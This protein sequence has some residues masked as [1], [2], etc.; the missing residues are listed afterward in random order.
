MHY[1]AIKRNVLAGFTTL[2]SAVY[3]TLAIPLMLKTIGIPTSEAFFTTCLVIGLTTCA[4]GLY[5]QQPIAA[6]PGLALTS[7]VCTEI[8]GRL[9]FTLPQTFAITITTGLIMIGLTR[10][11]LVKHIKHA[12]SETLI[13]ATGV[14][15]GLFFLIISI[16]LADIPNG[17]TLVHL[18][19]LIGWGGTLAV[20]LLLHH[21]QC[22]AAILAGLLL[23]TG[24]QHIGFPASTTPTNIGT[25]TLIPSWQPS[26]HGLLNMKA[27][28]AIS[29][30]ILVSVIDTIATLHALLDQ[31]QSQQASNKAAPKV[32]N[33]LGM[34]FMFSGA[35]GNGPIGIY[36]ESGTG[37]LSGGRN[38]LTS[39]T[40]GLGFLC[41]AGLHA[42]LYLIPQWA[43]AA[44]LS[45]VAIHMIKNGH[46][47]PWRYPKKMLAAATIFITVP[48]T[49]SIAIGVG[50][51]CIAEFLQNKWQRQ[52]NTPTLAW[53]SGLFAVFFIAMTWLHQSI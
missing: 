16:Q 22:P 28:F 8:V 18:H 44:A 38:W 27:F 52:P 36:L 10:L 17:H 30:L 42:W 39:V 13:T 6:G 25:F 9:H 2:L 29:T 46:K 45:F 53:L 41:C 33:T 32:L 15:I 34:A 23:A 12:L 26:W 31:H 50:A 5:S 3:I 49:M 24:L 7:F 43:T 19:A 11:G 4:L 47:L 40:T 21:Y 37:I 20:M 48:A 1:A 35:L 14:G 51:G